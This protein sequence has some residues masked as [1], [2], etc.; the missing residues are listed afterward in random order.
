MT[1]FLSCT[2]RHI[3][4]AFLSYRTA[5][6][7]RRR[8]RPG[9]PAWPPGQGKGGRWRTMTAQRT[10]ARARRP[11]VPP[12]RVL[13]EPVARRDAAQRLSLALTLLARGS[14]AAG[15]TEPAPRTAATPSL[16][17]PEAPTRKEWQG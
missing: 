4:R 6:P 2:S 1:A 7:V 16:R 11:P 15:G 10:D 12:R 8:W 13:L 17:D 5:S 3:P 9:R 14:G